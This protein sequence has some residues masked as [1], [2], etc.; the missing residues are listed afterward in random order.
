MKLYK[1][2]TFKTFIQASLEPGADGAACSRGERRGLS[3]WSE[4]RS[5]GKKGRPRQGRPF[6]KQIAVIIYYSTAGLP[7]E[8]S[9]Y[10]S[11]DIAAVR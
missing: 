6:D 10:F 8:L 1:V 3:E 11:N 2:D 5:Q 7:N 4:S 9:R